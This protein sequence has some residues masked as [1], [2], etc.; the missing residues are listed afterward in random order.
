MGAG[1]QRDTDNKSLASD[2]PICCR[3]ALMPSKLSVDTTARHFPN[4]RVTAFENLIPN[5]TDEA[6]LA[7]MARL[8]TIIERYWTTHLSASDEIDAFT[9]RQVRAILTEHRQKLH[10][11]G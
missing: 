3:A 7:E 8:L 6:M 11:R 5:M 10:T 1:E 2:S 4:G 9:V